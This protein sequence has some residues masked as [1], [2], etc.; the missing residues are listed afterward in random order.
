MSGA[1]RSLH[2]GAAVRKVANRLKRAQGQ[3]AAV[4]AAVEGGGDCRDVV[5]QLAAVSSAID[6]AGFAIISTAMRECI[7]DAPEAGGQETPERL[8]VDELEKLFL[9][10]A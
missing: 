9:T 4:I 10:L 1:D 8:T 2:D 6:R 5:T 7:T 3:L